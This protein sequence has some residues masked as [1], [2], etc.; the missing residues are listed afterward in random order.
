MKEKMFLIKR[1]VM[2]VLLLTAAIGVQAQKNMREV[3]V[4]MPDSVIPYLNH[5]LRVE[6]ADYWDMKADAKVKNRMDGETKLI[7]MSC[8]YMKL[9]LN[10]S[11]DASIRLLPT[12]DSTY[13]ICMIKTLK[14]P[15][16]ESSVMFYSSEWKPLDNSFGLPANDSSDKTKEMFTE[17]KDTLTTELYDKLYGMIEPVMLK[18]TLSETEE[19]IVFE[20]S[21]PFLTKKEKDE[22]SS[23]LRQRKFKWNGKT[24]KEC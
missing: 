14:A 11:T 6:L 19:T 21:L 23:I 15:A 17:L 2:S 16:E 10:G 24:F 1:A 3:W 4:T 8:G 12:S 7:K 13:I 5:K 22:V 9:E 20:L 18:A